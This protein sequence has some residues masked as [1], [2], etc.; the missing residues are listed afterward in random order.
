[1]PNFYKEQTVSKEDLKNLIANA[2]LFYWNSGD[3]EDFSAYLSIHFG[4]S[5]EAIDIFCATHERKIRKI[6]GNLVQIITE[7]V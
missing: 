3:L 6:S 5:E 2:S 1:M 7:A 4:W